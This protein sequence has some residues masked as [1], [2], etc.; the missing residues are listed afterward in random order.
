M[1]MIK[2]TDIENFQGDDR[3]R[4]ELMNLIRTDKI[5]TYEA[6]IKGD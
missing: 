4:D 3:L 1:R 2:L 6:T 5:K